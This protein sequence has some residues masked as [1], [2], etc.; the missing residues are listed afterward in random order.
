MK[1]EIGDGLHYNISYEF[2]DNGKNLNQIL[3]EQFL[4]YLRTNLKEN[5]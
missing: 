2:N 5:N 3:K 4:L 1:K